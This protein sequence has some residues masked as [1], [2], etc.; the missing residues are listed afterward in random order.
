MKCFYY[1]LNHLNHLNNLNDVYF[2]QN[3]LQSIPFADGFANGEP[4]DI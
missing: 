4:R 3:V 1:H 2:K